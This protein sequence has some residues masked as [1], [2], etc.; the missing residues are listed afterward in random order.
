MYLLSGPVDVLKYVDDLD[1]ACRKSGCAWYGKLGAYPTHSCPSPVSDAEDVDHLQF[2]LIFDERKEV[3]IAVLEVLSR[4]VFNPRMTAV[5]E[6]YLSMLCLYA[7]KFKDIVEIQ[8]VCLDV[9]VEVLG[10]LNGVELVVRSCEGVKEWLSTLRGEPWLEN[11]AM[12][13]VQC[14]ERAY[15]PVETLEGAVKTFEMWWERTK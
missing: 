6:N 2:I 5:N 7:K 12:M 14:I 11:R 3:K 13:V 8:S 1:V 9:L 10:K 15:V 4:R